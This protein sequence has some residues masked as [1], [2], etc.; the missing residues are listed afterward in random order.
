MS[1]RCQSDQIPAGIFRAYDIRGVVDTDLTPDVA[2][3]VA[4]A[5]AAEVL[6]IGSKTVV[7][8]R[9]ARLSGPGLMAAFQEGLLSSG[10]DIVD[11]GIVPSPLMYYAT[12]HLNIDCGIM[13][14]GSHNPPEYNGIKMILG[15]KSLS[16]NKVQ[17]LYLRLQRGDVIQGQGSRHE[18]DV[19]QAY[20]DEVS[21]A[22]PLVKPMKVMVWR[23]K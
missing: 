22:V 13:I 10:C 14:T 19:Q 20:I 15:G 7:V 3:D 17:D 4:K 18:D 8:G 23:V 6:A 9:D 11:I 21:K 2:H 12:H 16:G 1:L 5:Y